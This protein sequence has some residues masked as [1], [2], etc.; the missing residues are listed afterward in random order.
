MWEVLLGACPGPGT[1]WLLRLWAILWNADPPAS[2][3]LPAKVI[4][5]ER[6]GFAVREVVP[7]TTWAVAGRHRFARYQVVFRLSTSAPGATRLV[8]ESYATFPGTLGRAYRTVVIRLGLHTLVVRLMLS[9][10][11]RRAEARVSEATS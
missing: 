8:V 4:G 3:G 11:K 2:N 9:Y 7:S 6:P 10:L 1:P 5:A